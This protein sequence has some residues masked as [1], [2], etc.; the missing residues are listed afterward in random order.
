MRDCELRAGEIE[1]IIAWASNELDARL[2]A[3]LTDLC[4]SPEGS[5]ALMGDALWGEGL[6]GNSAAGPNE[7]ELNGC[8]L[9]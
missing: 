4:L 5:V 9:R 6:R 2:L 7:L 3:I 8:A 1:G